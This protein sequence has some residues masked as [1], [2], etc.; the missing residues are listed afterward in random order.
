VLKNPAIGKHQKGAFVKWV[1]K[2]A[3]K[4]IKN[5]PTISFDPLLASKET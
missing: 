4:F 1:V 2:T 5:F 3:L